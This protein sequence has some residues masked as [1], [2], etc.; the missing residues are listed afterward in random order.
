MGLRPEM[1]EMTKGSFFKTLRDSI[2]IAEINGGVENVTHRT[3][4]L[5]LR[6]NR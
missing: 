5:G 2:S 6:G 4:L 3:L 1:M